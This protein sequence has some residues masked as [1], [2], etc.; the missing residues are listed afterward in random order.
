MRENGDSILTL[1]NA[2]A[3]VATTDFSTKYISKKKSGRMPVKKNMIVV[4]SW[5][6]DSFRSIE[7]NKIKSIQPLSSILENKGIEEDNG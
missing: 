5:T 6:D 4:F 7:V 2:P 3:I 1:Q